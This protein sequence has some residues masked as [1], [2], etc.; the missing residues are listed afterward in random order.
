MKLKKIS[1]DYISLLK[2]ISLFFFYMVISSIQKEENVYS[3][4]VFIS[5][6]FSGSNIFLTLLLH[7]GT[8]L[9]NGGKGLLLAVSCSDGC[10]IITY[11]LYK[12]YKKQAGL[13][14]FTYSLLSLIPFVF[15]GNTLVFI[16]YTTRILQTVFSGLLTLVLFKTVKAVN[17]K[18]LKFKL[19]Y[20]EYLTVALSTVILGIGISNFT[21][22]L[23]WK[24]ICVFL[25]LLISYV[26]RIGISSLT[27]SIL[28]LSTAIY[29]ND[30][31]FVAVF[32]LL[33]VSTETVMPISRYLASCVIILTDYVIFYFFKAYGSYTLTDF[34]ATLI[35]TLTFTIIPCKIID[36]LKDKLYLF[37]EKQLTR[38]AINRSRIM[39]SNKLYDLSGVFTEI[40]SAFDSSSQKKID[41]AKAKKSI[42]KEIISN[43]CETCINKNVC[44]NQ[45]VE[46]EGLIEK[47][48]DIAIAKG[49]LTLIDFPKE[50]CE[51]CIHANNVLFAL[52]KMM[53]EYRKYLLEQMNMNL[54]RNLLKEETLG[55]SEV[56]R[57]LALETGTTLK[58][59]SK[60]EREIANELFCSGVLLS[61][62]LIYGEGK[63]T[64][65]SMVITMKEFSLSVIENAIK[66][67]SGFS[68][69]LC[70]KIDI[71]D[72]KVYLS[73]KISAEYDA[74]FGLSI[75]RKDGSLKSGD[76]YSV[77]RIKD[78]KFLVALS[79]GMGSGEEA[80]KISS[81]SLSLI[82]TFYKAGLS[83]ELILTT[84]NKLL[85]VNCEDN[86][87]ALDIAVVDL[88]KCACDFIKY[89]AP[90]GYIINKDGIKI[91]EGNTLPLG[92][93]D[94]L[95][96]S[97]AHT[98]LTDGDVLLLITDGVLDAFGSSGDI[99][100][101]LR[102]Q[103]A[104]NPQ[105]LSD[106]IMEKT[107][108]LTNGEKNDD[109][110]V[111]AV[112][113]FKKTA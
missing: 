64:S 108:S 5:S 66:K 111:L 98:N 39:L 34:F 41:E 48:I 53:G 77:L 82:E 36:K 52:N 15:L 105:N 73:F 57:G 11:L 88:K 83:D 65:V 51:N 40:A 99:I 38:Q 95:K 47:L 31:T 104:L 86:F 45:T 79:D 4:S 54:S 91:V 81:T 72:E 102:T 25:I 58:Y 87:T 112:R 3:V 107:L 101:F 62:L 10:I 8:L 2:Y 22:P 109:M 76:T 27:A 80:E 16:D 6:L 70:E 29:Y 59:Q 60:L 46:Q 28:G 78:D 24:A 90:Y 17:E 113:I 100:D 56:L 18:G 93:L 33:A 97:V 23:I 9:L 71:S 26:Y 110:T 12:K 84:I 49:K 19:N 44:K 68:M 55:V 13:E 7:F 35:P 67:I 85:N 92:I 63:N 14:I 96:P 1:F 69:T 42:K 74:V 20:E 106:K 89:G 94:D 32:L 61:E 30:V 37:R 43:V 21:S 75:G 103:P 50:L